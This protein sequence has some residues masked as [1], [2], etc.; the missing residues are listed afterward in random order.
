MSLN[1][2]S[3]LDRIEAKVD[4]LLQR[5]QEMAVDLTNLINAVA[6]EKTV[7]DSAIVLLGNLSAQIAALAKQP[8]V[9]PADLQAIADSITAN[10]TALAAAVV[11]N[12]PA[13]P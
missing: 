12:T 1:F 4:L 7:E 11:A 3:Q 6:A 8:T 9:N 13:A 10:K 2:W 5:S